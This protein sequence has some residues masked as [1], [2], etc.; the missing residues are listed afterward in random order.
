MYTRII[1]SILLAVGLSYSQYNVVLK[2]KLTGASMKIDV[3]DIESITFEKVQ[4]PDN[5]IVETRTYLILDRS[6]NPKYMLKIAC[7]WD[8]SGIPANCAQAFDTLNKN[9]T[10]LSGYTDRNGLVTLTAYVPVITWDGKESCTGFFHGI[11]CET[12][13]T[14]VDFVNNVYVYRIR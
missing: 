14:Y 1:L 6:D 4:K 11:K 13:L 7:D 10:K 3:A 2:N 12:P 9:N 5:C 8:R